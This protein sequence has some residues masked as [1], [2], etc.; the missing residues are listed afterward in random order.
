MWGEGGGEGAPRQWRGQAELLRSRSVPAARQ[1]CVSWPGLIKKG[2]CCHAKKVKEA[3]SKV[4]WFVVPAQPYN[5]PYK[6]MQKPAPCPRAPTH[7]EHCIV[8]RRAPLS[9]RRHITVQWHAQ[10]PPH[11]T[12]SSPSRRPLGPALRPKVPL[13]LAQTLS[14]QSALAVHANLLQ[15]VNVLCMHRTRPQTPHAGPHGRGPPTAPPPP[16]HYICYVLACK[17][18]EQQ[19]SLHAPS[20]PFPGRQQLHDLALAP[21]HV[22]RRSC[23]GPRKHARR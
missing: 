14:R 22:R 16:A 20:G 5:R 2:V 17:L 4:G 18:V 9:L 10:C 8:R 13:A 3:T 11:H 7:M 15:A 1:A 23:G 19:D 21:S 6:M 12:L